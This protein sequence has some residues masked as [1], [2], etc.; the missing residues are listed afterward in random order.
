MADM[1]GGDFDVIVVG[2]GLAGL[3]AAD[4]LI[5]RWPSSPARRILIIEGQ[6][7]VGGRVMTEERADGVD[8]GAAYVGTQQNYTQ[9]YMKR[10]GIGTINSNLPRHGWHVFQY[11]EKNEEPYYFAKKSFAPRPSA[12]AVAPGPDHELPRPGALALAAGP[13]YKRITETIAELE[14][15]IASVR[16]HVETPWN[17]PFRELDAMSVEDWIQARIPEHALYAREL[18]RVGVR[19]ALSVEPRELSMLYLLYYCATAGGFVNLMAVGGGADSFRVKGGASKLARC[20]EEAIRDSSRPDGVSCVLR[21]MQRVVRIEQPSSTTDKATVEASSENSKVRFTARHVIVAMS[22]PLS[23]NIQYQPSLPEQRVGLAENMTMGATI[24]AFAVYSKPWWKQRSPKNHVGGYSG[25]TLSARGPISWT[26][27]N[28]WEDNTEKEVHCLMAFI[29]GDQA[30]R[31]SGSDP[32]DRKSAILKHLVELFGGA[33]EAKE[34]Q[35]YYERVWPTDPWSRGCPAAVFGPGK[36]IKYGPALREPC[37]RIHWAGSE[38][39]TDWVGGYMNGAIQSGIRAAD[40]VMAEIAR[41]EAPPK[42]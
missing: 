26:M 35:A 16:C 33:E 10:F 9:L 7:R 11:A 8:L 40:A 3:T 22:P 25:Y 23:A 28:S 37:G 29:V 24:K 18:F 20:L 34:Y 27:D 6:D 19:S 30:R 12:L 1:N 17:G 31:L 21:Q 42:G 36:F 15:M 13:D 2:A 41:E 32:D 38:A 14:F 4:W 39:A 5:Q